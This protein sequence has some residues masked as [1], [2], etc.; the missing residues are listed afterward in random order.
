MSDHNSSW[1]QQFA[2]L[3]NHVHVADTVLSGPS[4]SPEEFLLYTV[5]YPLSFLPAASNAEVSRDQNESGKYV[6]FPASRNLHNRRR[7]LACLDVLSVLLQLTY[8]VRFS[9]RYVFRWLFC[10]LWNHIFLKQLPAF[11]RNML[12]PSSQL[13]VWDGGDK[14]KWIAFEWN[15]YRAH[16][17]IFF[18]EMRGILKYRLLTD[19]SHF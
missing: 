4:G 13:S 2:T 18:D 7:L 12:P 10:V 1:A 8:D 9:R 15:F 16:L 11:Q 3:L 5:L 19:T 14:R 17:C 6:C